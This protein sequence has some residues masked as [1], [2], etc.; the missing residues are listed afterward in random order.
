MNESDLSKLLTMEINENKDDEL[1]TELE[2]ELKNEFENLQNDNQEEIELPLEEEVDTALP[3]ERD[4]FLIALETGSIEDLQ[5]LINEYKSNAVQ[6]KRVNNNEMAISYMKAIKLLQ[7]KIK[8]SQPLEL[9]EK[10]ISATQKQIQPSQTTKVEPI[11]DRKVLEQLHS[12]IFIS[13]L[14]AK[15]FLKLHQD[16]FATYFYQLHKL[17]KSSL[18]HYPTPLVQRS[19]EWTEP[20]YNPFVHPHT[21]QVE[22]QFVDGIVASNDGSE[23]YFILSM[24]PPNEPLLHFNHEEIVKSQACSL[25]FPS[26]SH[27]DINQKFHFQVPSKIRKH[28]VI[29]LCKVYPTRFWEYLTGPKIDKIGKIQLDLNQTLKNGN[30]ATFEYS[31]TL[32]LMNIRQPTGIHL[33][34]IVRSRLLLNQSANVQRKE[35][36]YFE[37]PIVSPSQ[38]SIAD[39]RVAT[40]LA[41]TVT[42]NSAKPINPVQSPVQTPVTPIATP[43]TST[44][45][46]TP[47]T[48]TPTPTS[49]ESDQIDFND[50]LLNPENMISNLVYEYYLQLWS[51]NKE[52]EGEVQEIQIKMNFLGIKVSTGQLTMDG[53]AELLSKRLQVL[54]TTAITLKNDKN[55][56]LAQEALLQIKKIQQEL[57]ELKQ[58]QQ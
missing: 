8:E 46:N 27:F 15:I 6:E 12:Q 53:Y 7:A 11:L 14:Y 22:L 41:S 51:S 35:I 4:D 42:S 45:T 57:L 30:Y 19:V 24:G 29:T 18:E 16:T 2:N 52:K 28:L 58:M 48:N 43:T 32:Q 13:S 3:H 49:P 1:D 55:L 26:Q 37:E 5:I 50:I 10:V 54:K 44:P 47:A 23:L 40:P 17:S 33:K 20:P 21:I 9:E 36:W 31:Q 38:S 39:T 25:K 56:V 34:M